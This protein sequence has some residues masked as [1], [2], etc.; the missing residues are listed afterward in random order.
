MATKKAENTRG[1]G[2]EVIQRHKGGAAAGNHVKGVTGIR[3][4]SLHKALQAAAKACGECEAWRVVEIP[5]GEPL[6]YDGVCVGEVMW[7]RIG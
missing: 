1:W 7:E 2:Y 3:F 5:P 6:D 4:R